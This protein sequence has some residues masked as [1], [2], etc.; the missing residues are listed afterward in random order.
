MLWCAGV[1]I[2]GDRYPGSNFLDH[3]LR[4]QAN[5]NVKML[6]LLGE[7]GGTD[8][9]DICAAM[10]DG[11]I[12]KPIVA[13]CIGTCAKVRC[14]GHIHVEVHPRVCGCVGGC[15]SVD[16]RGWGLGCAGGRIA[17]E[18]AITPPV[19]C[20]SPPPPPFH[21]LFIPPPRPPLQMFPFE[22]QFGHA[23]A[24]ANSAAQTAEAKNAYVTNNWP[25]HTG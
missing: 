17:G 10:K 20:L 18:G 22:V 19:L 21:L 16:G 14:V 9:Y 7:V 5:P 25:R 8:E 2:G 12:T 13:W 11:R 15:R 23:G 1:A 4:Y 6:V 3:M 24:L